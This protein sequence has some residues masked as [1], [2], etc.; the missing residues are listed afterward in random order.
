MR[1]SRQKYPI[2]KC[3]S[4]LYK[5]RLYNGIIV[6]GLNV[7]IV[8]DYWQPLENELAQYCD[9]WESNSV[10]ITDIEYCSL[11]DIILYQW[12]FI[13]SAAQTQALKCPIPDMTYISDPY[14]S[15]LAKK[16]LIKE[17]EKISNIFDET[18]KNLF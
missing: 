12:N 14:M 1:P 2:N 17:Y 18:I 11:R 8:D 13:M 3:R 4:L 16:S 15:Y 5:P 10:Y 6:L 7:K 9:I